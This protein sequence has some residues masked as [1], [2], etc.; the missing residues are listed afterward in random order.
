MTTLQIALPHEQRP[1]GGPEVLVY[2]DGPQLFWL[3]CDGRRLLAVA[4]PGFVGRWPFLVV[5]LTAAQA[6]DIVGDR[7]TLQAAC[8]AATAAWVLR[9]YDARMLELEPLTVIPPNWLPGNVML[10]LTGGSACQ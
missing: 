10:G 6:Q 5:E 2:Y 1:F 8:Q 3:P 4:L 9:D 7:L